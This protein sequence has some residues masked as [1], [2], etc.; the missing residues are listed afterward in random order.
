MV[1]F[2]LMHI[3]PVFFI[4]SLLCSSAVAIWL[5]PG[6]C[7]AVRRRRNVKINDAAMIVIALF[8]IAALAVPDTFFA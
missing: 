3:H 7:Y 6:V 5:L 1:G 8:V 2:S 4:A